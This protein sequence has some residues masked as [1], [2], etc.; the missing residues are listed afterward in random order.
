MRRYSI[1]SIAV[2]SA[3]LTGCT[4]GIVGDWACILLSDEE[5]PY[6]YS[7]SYSSEGEDVS[8]SGSYSYSASLTVFSDFSGHFTLAYQFNYSWGYEGKSYE[9]SYDY[10]YVYRVGVEKEGVRN[11][12]ITVENMGISLSCERTADTLDCED[13]GGS[14]TQFVQED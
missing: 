6:D 3:N 9:M 7:Y 13:Q 4:D 11:Y 1:P 5:M 14:A 12:A 10:A 8:Y 2:F